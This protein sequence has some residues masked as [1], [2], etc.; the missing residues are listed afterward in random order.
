[1]K[2]ELINIYHWI[3]FIY[4]KITCTLN[5]DITATDCGY[6]PNTQITATSCG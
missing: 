1:M 4:K 2:K 6:I 3:S 5:K